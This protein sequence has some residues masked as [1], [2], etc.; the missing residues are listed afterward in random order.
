MSV[1]QGIARRVVALSSGDVYRAYGIFRGTETV[2][3]QPVP[4]AEDAPLRDRLYPYRGERMHAPD[5]PASWIDDYEKILVERAVLGNS[6]LPGTVLRLPMI[7]GPGDD[8]HRLF[9]YLKRMD[10]GRP[11]IVMDDVRAAWRWAKG[12]VENVADAIVAA[13]V[14]ERAAGRIYNIS[15]LDTLTEA[16]WV[17]A[18]AQAAGWRG[19]VI[20]VPRAEMPGGLLKPGH[21]EQHLEYDTRRI[22]AELGYIERSPR[23]EAIER[24][25]EWERAHPPEQFDPW[26]FDYELEDEVLES[27][28]SQGR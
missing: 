4:I 12:Y 13:V 17:R 11:A 21:F 1:H 20:V 10:D 8:H 3:L 27:L 9:S 22:R 6:S 14:D 15:E 23:S 26:E 2:P 25:V 19:Q 7:Y 24:T 16:D 5:D 18:I 28:P